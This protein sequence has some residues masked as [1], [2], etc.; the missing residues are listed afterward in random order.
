VRHRCKQQSQKQ[1]K[2]VRDSR[3][4]GASNK[5]AQQKTNKKKRSKTVRKVKRGASSRITSQPNFFSDVST[6][7]CQSCTHPRCECV[8]SAIKA[9]KSYIGAV[10]ELRRLPLT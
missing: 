10:S 8:R 3:Q 5:I 9:E 7:S 4:Y 6:R 1:N 2:G